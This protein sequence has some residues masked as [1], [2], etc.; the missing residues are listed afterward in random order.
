MTDNKGLKVI[1][2]QCRKM[3]VKGSN[4][5]E[6]IITDLSYNGPFTCTAK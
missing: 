4:A 5:F 2:V 1:K 3:K 6:T